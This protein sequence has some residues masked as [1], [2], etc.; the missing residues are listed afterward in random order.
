MEVIV[1]I[2][3]VQNIE[4]DVKTAASMK[5]LRGAPWARSRPA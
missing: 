4:E 1:E 3:S 2:R 5:G